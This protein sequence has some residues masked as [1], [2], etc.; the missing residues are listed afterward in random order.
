[1]KKI[2]AAFC[3]P[4]GGVGKSTISKE[5]TNIIGATKI[6]GDY[7]RV[8]L[9]DGNIEFGSQTTF[10]QIPT[11]PDDLESF[12]LDHRKLLETKS[13]REIEQMYDWNYIQK[14]LVKIGPMEENMF[15]LPAPPHASSVEIKAE[16][17]GMLIKALFNSFDVVILDTPN[18]T[19]D[20]T[21]SA[22]EHADKLFFIAVD[23][24]RSITNLQK[25]RKKLIAEHLLDRANETG[26]IIYN[27]YHSEKNRQF[28]TID[29][30]MELTQ[31][32]VIL[33]I[34][35][36]P[37]FETYNALAHPLTDHDTPITNDFYELAQLIVPEV[38]KPKLKKI[39][40]TDLKAR[41]ME[42]FRKN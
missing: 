8:V 23:D 32:P 35:D 20:T 33:T 6:G 29:D 37:Q 12:I 5:V 25:L 9:V 39:N 34:D 18:N 14:Y 36:Y 41:I 21:I 42:R 13:D 24:S 28:Y 15:L 17:A 10:W 11:Y 30:M 31:F 38:E 3:S 4:S 27:R 1:M 22:I 26:Q 40:T 7:V 19:K 16:E 2:I